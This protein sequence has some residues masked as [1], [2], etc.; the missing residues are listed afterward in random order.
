MR[1]SRFDIRFAPFVA[2]Q[3]FLVFDHFARSVHGPFEVV[4]VLDGVGRAGVY[5]KSAQDAAAIINLINPGVAMIHAYA[6][7]VRSRIFCAFDVNRVCRAGRRAQKARHA[8]L[9]AVIVDVQEV[10]AS[11]AAVDSDSFF[12]VT[13]SFFFGWDVAE[14]DAHAL[15]R[16]AS[17]FNHVFYC[18][19][20]V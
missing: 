2:E 15:C 8:K 6:L 19:D 20:D 9:F 11:E 14:R 12:G 3:I 13:D 17:D 10:F 18:V 5:A 1:R 4:A 7:I 16:G